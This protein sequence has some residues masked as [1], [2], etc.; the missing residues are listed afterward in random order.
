MDKMKYALLT[1]TTG[2]WEANIIENFLKA[3][4][5]DAILV[6]EAISHLTHPTSFALSRFMFQ[7]Q[8]S[9]RRAVW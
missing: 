6:Q 2:R 7:N 5:I 1:E 4:G 8:V 9:G 3:D